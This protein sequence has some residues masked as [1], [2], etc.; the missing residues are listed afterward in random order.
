M[1]MRGKSLVILTIGNV[2]TGY[3]F[4]TQV[5]CGAFVAVFFLVLQLVARPYIH[6]LM[7]YLEG[8]CAVS[9][10]FYAFVAIFLTKVDYPDDQTVC[11][12]IQAAMKRTHQV[13]VHT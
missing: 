7:D 3:V 13:V 2:K 1:R 11:A 5:S 8:L 10:F 6:D 9:I 12:N 4:S